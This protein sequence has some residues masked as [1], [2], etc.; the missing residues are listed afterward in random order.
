MQARSILLIAFL[1]VLVG[2]EHADPRKHQVASNEPP[3][4]Q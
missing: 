1:F 3:P 4:N 2:C